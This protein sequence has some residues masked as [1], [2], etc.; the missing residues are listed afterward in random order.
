MFPTIIRDHSPMDDYKKIQSQIKY[1]VEYAPFFDTE[2][3]DHKE[4]P[5]INKVYQFAYSA[6]INLLIVAGIGVAASIILAFVF[7]HD[8]FT[9]LEKKILLVIFLVT[10]A[11]FGAPHLIL[12]IGTPIELHSEKKYREISI[13]LD[14]KTWILNNGQVAVSDEQKYRCMQKYDSK[15]ILPISE[16]PFKKMIIVYKVYSITRVDGRIIVDADVRELYRK[17]PYVDDGSAR[18]ES[19]NVDRVYYYCQKDK[20]DKILWYENMYGRERLLVALNKMKA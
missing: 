2:K 3:H 4:K 19:E 20:R 15:T 5:S 13:S 7:S 18:N 11:S 6:V 9:D 1:K 10:I 12:G 8:S 17:H 16:A 14:R